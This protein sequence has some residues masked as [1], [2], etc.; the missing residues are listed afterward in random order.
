RAPGQGGAPALGRE[1]GRRRRGRRRGHVREA[2]AGRGREAGQVR[3]T[4]VLGVDPGTRYVGY[5]VLRVDQGW[6]EVAAAGVVEVPGADPEVDPREDLVG[7]TREA[8]RALTAA[9]GEYHPSVVAAEDFLM[10]SRSANI[11]VQRQVMLTIGGVAA[12]L[13]RK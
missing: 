8:A 7:R 12:M 10:F 4:T 1:S 11:Q 2:P 13:G 3:R 6:R 5:A 9:V